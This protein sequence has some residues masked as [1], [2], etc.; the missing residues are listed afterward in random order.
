[1]AANDLLGDFRKLLLNGICSWFSPAI[2]ISSPR[3]YNTH[4]VSS[5]R[6][7]SLK[8]V[9]NTH[10]SATEICVQHTHR[11]PPRSVYTHIVSHRDLCTTHSSSVTEICVQHTHRQS[12]RS[13]Y[14]T[15]I[16]SHRDMC[17]THTHCQPPRP[18][19]NTH[20]VNHR[21][22]CTT[23]TSSAVREWHQCDLCTCNTHITGCESD[24]TE[25]RVQHTTSS[26]T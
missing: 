22:L 17:T 21:D 13:V 18:V 4:V 1:M 8:S 3:L 23:R 2:V 12:P 24:D 16:V 10:T 20:I 5:E 15:H 26:V 9:Y 6:M 14:N 7:S 11:Q 25:I 19:Y